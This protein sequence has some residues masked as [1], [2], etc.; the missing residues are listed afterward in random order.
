M[1]KRYKTAIRNENVAGILPTKEES[2]ND[3]EYSEN[4]PI[5]YVFVNNVNSS[6][7]VL[8]SNHGC[9]CKDILLLFLL[10][11]AR[12]LLYTNNVYPPVVQQYI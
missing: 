7:S 12:A 6:T 8:R 2:G 1:V 9:I 11:T 3:R 4:V 5:Q 10:L